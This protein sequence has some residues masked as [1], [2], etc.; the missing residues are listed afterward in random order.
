[1]ERLQARRAVAR[2]LGRPQREEPGAH[3]HRPAHRLCLAVGHHD[4]RRDLLVRAQAL[5]LVGVGSFEHE[6]VLQ[7]DARR[8]AGWP[9]VV[10]NGRDDIDAVAILDRAGQHLARCAEDGDGALPARELG[11]DAGLRE[12]LELAERDLLALVDRIGGRP[13]RSAAQR[14]RPSRRRACAWARTPSSGSRPRPRSSPAVPA[15]MSREA[16]RTF[17]RPAPSLTLFR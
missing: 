12:R 2:D 7:D 3:L 17:T 6:Q 14:S 10:P 8:R 9:R 15:G 11:E 16:T 13:W 5:R 4:R 1:M